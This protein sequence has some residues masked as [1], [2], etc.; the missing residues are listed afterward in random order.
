MNQFWK[1]TALAAALGSFAFAQQPKSKKEGEAL[2]AIQSATTPEA[3]L[4]AIENLLTKFADTEYKV[5]ALEIAS[6]T[7]QQKNDA[8]QTVIY[9][10]RLLEADP[11]NLNGIST[12][13]KVTAGGIRE[14]DLDKED[15]LKRVDELA[16][17]CLKLAPDSK[18]PNKMMTEE[19]W[20]ARKNEFLADCHDAIAAAAIL[21][22]KVDV[23]VAE[24]QASLA[25]RKDPATMVRIA[26]VYTA[27]GKYDDSIAMLEKVQAIPD[28][29][30]VVRQVAGNERVKA[31]MARQKV[32]AAEA[33][34]P[35]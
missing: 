21:R 19:Q 9:A 1:W 30:P 7:V 34:K 23:A 35:Q 32:K 26:Q 10:E 3:R 16:G 18:N 14:N 4:E 25:L 31:I 28:V 22:K 5:I 17:T 27:Q 12:L 33:P 29:N 11:K 13:A 8:V 6:D 20:A 24:Y 2:I 15:K